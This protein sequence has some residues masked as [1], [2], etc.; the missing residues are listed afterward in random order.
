MNGRGHGFVV[1]G[2]VCL[3]PVKINVSSSPD[4]PKTA[5]KNIVVTRVSGGGGGPVVPIRFPYCH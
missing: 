5:T 4:G 2:P 1:P 3:S